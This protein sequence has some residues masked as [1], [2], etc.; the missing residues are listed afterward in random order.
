MTEAE[1]QRDPALQARILRNRLCSARDTAGL[2]QAQAARPLDWSPAKI[3]RIENGQT[4]PTSADVR[5]L[6]DVYGITDTRARADWVALTRAARAPDWAVGLR[7]ALPP[8]Y[9]DY[10]GCLL[11]AGAVRQVQ[12]HV[13]PELAQTPRYARAV[14]NAWAGVRDTPADLD[15]FA[16]AH[17][18]WVTR[19]WQ[20]STPRPAPA[21]TLS[22]ILDEAVLRRRVGG[23][24]VMAEQLRHLRD[25]ARHPRMCLRILPMAVASPALRGPFEILDVQEPTLGPL[26]V[27]GDAM[28]YPRMI[29]DPAAVAEKLT[30]FERV[31]KLAAP[32]EQTDAVVEEAITRLAGPGP[33]KGALFKVCQAPPRSTRV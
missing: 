28:G 16:A 25:L 33:L 6:L 24:E 30:D 29:D 4:T 14:Q 12:T 15:Q 2:T 17:Q 5:A 9:I 10:V 31:E 27:E 19:L 1:G 20:P 7:G 21:P 23:L 32:A 8:A 3:L 22:V 13:I 11:G 26:L 18:R